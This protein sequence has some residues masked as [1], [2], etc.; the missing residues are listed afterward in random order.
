MSIQF[1][2]KML[3]IMYIIIRVR[4]IIGVFKCIH[5]LGSIGMYNQNWSMKMLKKEKVKETILYS[6]KYGSEIYANND[7]IMLKKNIMTFKY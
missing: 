5:T 6:S 1:M 7:D 3:V 2:Q 4:I